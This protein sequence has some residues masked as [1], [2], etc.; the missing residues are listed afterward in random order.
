MAIVL[1]ITPRCVTS[2]AHSVV[3]AQLV[4]LPVGIFTAA[5]IDLLSTA[6]SQHNRIIIGV[7]G[8]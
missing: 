6:A 8:T 4:R 2:R 7:F 5:L 1:K 3:I